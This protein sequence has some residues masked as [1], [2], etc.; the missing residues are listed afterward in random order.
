MTGSASARAKNVAVNRR[1]RHDYHVLET[2]EAGIALCGT[3]VKSVRAGQ[4]SLAGAFVR[5]D[6]GNAVLQHATIAP[7]EHGN[8][9]NHESDRPR[10]LLLHKREIL[11]L[12][13]QAEQKGHALVPLSVFLRR[14]LV[15][16][17]IGVC[18]GKQVHDKR[19]T[20]R[21]RTADR[22]AQ[23]AIANARRS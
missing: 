17:Q 6:D 5:I 10:R 19:E 11:K 21:R 16:L 12:Q 7:Y 3:E 22:E 18:R 15:K 9:F 8:R 2:Y 20:I 13:A 4:I 23:R 14:G 1:A